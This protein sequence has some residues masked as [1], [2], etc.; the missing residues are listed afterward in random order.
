MNHAVLRYENL[1][2]R[3]KGEER[4]L[5]INAVYQVKYWKKCTQ[6]E[7]IEI[8]LENCESQPE[9]SLAQIAKELGLKEYMVKNAYA[10]ALKKMRAYLQK[11]GKSYYDFIEEGE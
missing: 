4:Q 3:F 8:Y 10:S 5:R 6:A 11:Q 2:Q 9:M 7:A 1:I